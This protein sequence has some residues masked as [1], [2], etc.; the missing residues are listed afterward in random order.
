MIR[1]G[2]L[3]YQLV[4]LPGLL[5]IRSV[6][7]WIK[8]AR[9]NRVFYDP[10]AF[11]WIAAMEKG[12]AAIQSELALVLRDVDGIP[13][14]P[15]I[16]AEQARITKGDWRTFF[17]FAYGHRVEENCRRCPQTARLLETIPGMTSAMFSILEPGAHLTPHRGPFKGVLRYHL[18]LQVPEPREAC[19]IR[20]AGE[21][22][23]WQEG[24]SLVFDDT[25]EHEAWNR[26]AGTRVVLFV[27]VV[28]DLPGPLSAVNRGMI[29]LIGASPFVR[30]L[31][32]NVNALGRRVGD[33]D[34]R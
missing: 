4:A 21:V 23:H 22:R 26:S 19:G 25:H 15:E 7:L 11:P 10:A 32:Q 8:L 28:R 30:N 9:G 13:R 18:A 6:E 31:V 2:T 33:F 16:S 17:F 3:L 14:F 34:R 27:D 29:R 12:T 20:V 24:K 1:K 5:L